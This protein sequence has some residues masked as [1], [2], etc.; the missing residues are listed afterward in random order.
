MLCGICFPMAKEEGVGITDIFGS[1][2][3]LHNEWN[4][5]KYLL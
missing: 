1:A 5:C 4:R 3:T 2:A